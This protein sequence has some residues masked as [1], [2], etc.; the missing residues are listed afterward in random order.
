MA[1]IEKVKRS[2][3]DIGLTEY[4]IKTYLILLEHGKLTASQISKED[5][6]PFSKIYEVLGSLEK[7][8]W[9]E[10]EHGRPARYYPKSPSSALDTMR[11]RDERDWTTNATEIIKELVP[12]YEKKEVRE[13][14]DI[15]IV[16]GTFNIVTKVKETLET[17]GKEVLLAVPSLLGEALT[18]LTPMLHTIK[19]RGIRIRILTTGDVR[20]PVLRKASALGEVKTREKL[21]GG[22][23][24]SD[25]RA[26]ILLLGGEN[27]ASPLAIWSEH[28]GLAG[29][30]KEYFEF[31]WSGSRIPSAKD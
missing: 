20:N 23:V 29:F 2:L 10:V 18:L 17:S 28:T 22:G 11:M 30:A 13:R 24:I 4:E 12:I 3:A 31:L 14:P 9:L 16:R 1:I 25:G 7:K 6:P 15:W 8:G 27:E 19:E 5:G 26:V 21:F